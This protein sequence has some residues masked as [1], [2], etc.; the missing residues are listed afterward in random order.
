MLTFNYLGYLGRIGNQ[1][2]QYAAL[3]GISAQHNYEY[4]LPPNML[5]NGEM[6]IHLYDCFDIRNLDKKISNWSNYEERSPSTHEFDEN[7]FYN[8]PP[9][10]DLFGYFQTEKYFKN[11]DSII[12]DDFTFRDQIL[13]DSKNYFNG[14]FNDNEVISLHI[15]RTDYVD[16]NIMR[17]LKLSYYKNALSYFDSKIPVLVFS[18]D[19]EWCKTQEIFSGDRFK[20][21]NNSTY[22]D[23]CL[24]SM[25]K[26]HIVANSTFSWWGAWLAKSERTVSPRE[27]YFT[28]RVR[29]E[30]PYLPDY[31]WNSI[32]ISPTHWILL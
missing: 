22:V 28:N 7:F 2:F 31:D 9:Q 18:D 15:R 20:F 27:W 13:N 26:Y 1:M 17:L 30:D 14:L 16:N 5:D 24:M 12:R 10:T 25:C 21:S 8:C 6:Y 4:S 19:I 32:D 23:L 3:R 11:I 29:I